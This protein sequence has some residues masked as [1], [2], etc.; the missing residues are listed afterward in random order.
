MIFEGTW[1]ESNK[2]CTFATDPSEIYAAVESGK[3][4]VLHVPEVTVTGLGPSELYAV[5]E[6]ITQSSKE[7]DSQTV[8]NYL[9]S[10]TVADGYFGYFDYDDAGTHFA[11]RMNDVNN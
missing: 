7:V 6:T 8:Y 2:V 11:F 1:D 9:Y 5:I 10:V 4:A 3:I